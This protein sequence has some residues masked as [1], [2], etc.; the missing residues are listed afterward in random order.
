MST[1][2][3]TP[4]LRYPVGKFTY[5]GPFSEAKQRELIQQIADAPARM[6]AAVA[7]LNE[8]QLNTP[9]RDGG[10]TVRQVVHH[11]VDSHMNSY[12]R[13]RWTLTENE[14]AIKI[15]DEKTWA[16]LPDAKSAPVELSLSLLNTL[17]ARWVVL[18][19]ALTPE[20]WKRTLRHPEAGVM[21]LDRLL[22]LYAWHGRHHVAHVTALRERMG[23]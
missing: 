6:R 13:F 16:E 4:D 20:D 22:G 17:H 1:T 7:G 14:P 5:E 2:V 8:A 3:T 23:W 11:I 21:T 10:W 12:I 15:Y 18:L 19:L 9:Y